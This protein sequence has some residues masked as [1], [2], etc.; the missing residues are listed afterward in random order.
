MASSSTPGYPSTSEQE[1][2]VPYLYQLGQAF[3]LHLNFKL[4][5]CESICQGPV[6]DYQ[7]YQCLEV[8]VAYSFICL[9][10]LKPRET[11]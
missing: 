8:I 10:P 5:T 2:A 9:I 4:F 7:C 6:T 1:Q 11:A 3:Q